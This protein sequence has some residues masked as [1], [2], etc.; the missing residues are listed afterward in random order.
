[1]KLDNQRDLGKTLAW[2]QENWFQLSENDDYHE[3]EVI[4]TKKQSGLDEY[5][6]K[7]YLQWIWENQKKVAF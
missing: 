3:S 4:I 6:V 1:M 7:Y 2:S 5:R